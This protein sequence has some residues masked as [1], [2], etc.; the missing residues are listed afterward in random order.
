MRNAARRVVCAFIYALIFGFSASGVPAQ[1]PN[2]VAQ[3]PAPAITIKAVEIRGNRRVDRSTILFYIKLSEGKSYTN[4]DL[5]E[6]IRKDVR[7]IYSLGFFRDVKVDVEPFEGGLRVTYRITEKPTIRKVVFRGN[8]NV[9]EE[10]IRERLTVKVQTIVNEATI[11]ETVRN[12]RK[13][14]QEEGYYFARVEAV[15]KEGAR[16]TVDVT[17]NISEG[18]SVEIETVQFRGNESIS[19]KDILGVMSTDEAGFWSFITESGIFKE[20]E[21]EK[22]ILRI[23]L[24]YQSRGYFKAQVGQPVIKEDRDRGKLNIVITISEG[25]KYN[26]GDIEIRGGED[27]VPPE[28]LKKNFRLFPGETFNRT[29]MISD[30]Q[31]VTTSF[32]AKGY[33]FVDVI[34]STRADDDKKTVNLL[35]EIKKGR[36]VYIGR[37]TIK[38][39]TRTRENVVR[40]E[41]RVTEG[42]LYDSKGL[43]ATRQR[44]QKLGYF[45]DVKLVEKRR[46]RSDEILDIDIEVK[47]R[48]TGSI[49]GGVG[50][51]SSEGTILTASI[52]EEN[53]FGKGYFVSFGGSL[54]AETQRLVAS[55]NNPN[56]RDKDFSLGADIFLTDEEFPT[57]DN[58]RKGGR[59][60][61]G[62]SLTDALSAF[63]SYEL[64]TSR[65]RNVSELAF[66]DIIDLEGED[67]FESKLA[68]A[69]VYDSRNSRFLPEKGTLFAV[70]P[71]IAG[72]P[73]GGDIDV[74][75]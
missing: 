43:A 65:L 34:P 42:A 24:L 10:K 1:E 62:K 69:I 23:R 15:L 71:S 2:I 72:G 51:N 31:G 30:I 21:L 59:I 54:S 20:D 17:L 37:V 47:E 5:V 35:Y 61:V 44:L 32:A 4:V 68:P 63:L 27:V 50:F 70:T 9:E 36:R 41:V 48:P 28:E 3:A 16:N 12:I 39:N 45:A 18:K 52:R 11:K 7:T 49:G 46:P 14:Y 25:F 26:T 74:G 19:R 33:A 60:N 55:F 38:G 56:F 73:L 22:D 53:L 6:R 13:L 57:F 58:E 8:V 40:R 75:F 66:Q 64:S 29:F 67:L